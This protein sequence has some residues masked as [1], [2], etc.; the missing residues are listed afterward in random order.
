MISWMLQM[1]LADLQADVAYV[2]KSISAVFLEA[3]PKQPPNQGWCARRQEAEVRILFDDPGNGLR[4]VRTGERLSRRQDLVQHYAKRP[5][6]RPLVD[7]LATRL[8]RRHIRGGAHD[9]AHLRGGG[10]QRRR[11]RGVA[12]G[13]RVE[14]L[15]QAE[16]Q[17]LDGAVFLH[18]DV[19]GFEV[20]VDHASLVS[21]FERLGYL[22]GNW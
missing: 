7:R 21:R 20:A 8:L 12:F 15:C 13:R 16:V 4:H 22:S 18:L 19:G 5:D 11:L 14:G 17:D 1:G 10:G 2:L 3:A 6:I 9:D